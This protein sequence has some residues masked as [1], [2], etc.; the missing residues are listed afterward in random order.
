VSPVATKRAADLRCPRCD[1]PLRPDQDWCLECGSAATTRVLPPPSWG[2]AALIV[3]GIVALA[4]VA[5]ALAVDQ[6]SDEADRAASSAPPAARTQPA[7][8]A[9]APAQTSQATAPA[10]APTPT[11]AT[12]A[13]T[14]ARGAIAS[15]PGGRQGWTVIIRQTRSRGEA[16]GRARQLAGRGVQVGLLRSNDFT[17]L[18]QGFWMVFS[19]VFSSRAQAAGHQRRLGNRAPATAYFTAVTPRRR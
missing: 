12:T 1:A 10:A 19:G 3:L 11:T 18:D 2:V 8:T 6:L 4:G 15:W 14:S 9:T 5:L 17:T 7:P 16:E 13:T